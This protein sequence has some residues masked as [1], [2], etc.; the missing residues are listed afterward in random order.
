MN[1]AWAALIAAIFLEV[2]GTTSMKISHGFSRLWPSVLIFVFYGLS[3]AGLTLALRRLD[4]SVAY[5]VWSGLGTAVVA[6]IGVVYFKESLSLLKVASLALIV[7]GLLG[8][9]Y[10]A[11]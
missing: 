5:A 8:L 9:N 11:H 7:I 4:V 6:I 10:S 1:R 2:A 3:L